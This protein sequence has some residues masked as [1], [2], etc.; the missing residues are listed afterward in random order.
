MLLDVAGQDCQAIH[1]VK[2]DLFIQEF[3]ESRGE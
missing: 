2:V 1:D 3:D